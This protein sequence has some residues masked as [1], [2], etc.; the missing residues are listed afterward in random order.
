MEFV[1]GKTEEKTR[2]FRPT[3]GKQMNI[4]AYN[5]VITREQF[6]FMKFE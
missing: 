5:A 1:P 4:K 6:C 3:R 2:N